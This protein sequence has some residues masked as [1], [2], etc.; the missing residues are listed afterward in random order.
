MTNAK[1]AERG[2]K[3]ILKGKKLLQGWV[4]IPHMAYYEVPESLACIKGRCIV[5]T[6][7]RYFLFQW[8]QS[9]RLILGPANTVVKA[10]ESTYVWTKIAN[11]GTPSKVLHKLFTQNESNFWE[12]QVAKAMGGT[13]SDLN[14][15]PN[16]FVISFFVK[17][18]KRKLDFVGKNELN[19]R[20]KFGLEMMRHF[21]CIVS[22]FIFQ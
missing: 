12:A 8:I 11:T 3:A 7:S 19:C 10:Q 13:S 16:L 6:F 17:E 4:Q 2:K 1:I 21:T 9:N 15:K 14:F 20:V 22:G 18:L 5:G